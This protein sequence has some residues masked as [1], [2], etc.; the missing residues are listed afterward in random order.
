VRHST[1]DF[2]AGYRDG[3]ERLSA[4]IRSA[5]TGAADRTVPL[6]P[7]WRV[8]D[9]VA[10]VVGVCEDSVAADYPDFSDPKRQPDQA[11]AREAWTSAQVARRR[12][13]PMEEVIA[14]WDVLGPQLEA[15]LDT[16]TGADGRP[17]AR[18]L[19]APFDLG[20]HL[21][22]V[23]HA[24]AKPGDHDAP[25]TQIAFALAR[26]WLDVRIRTAGLPALRLQTTDRD[27]V[28][29]AGSAAV[30]VHGTRF[31]LF[32][33]ITGRRSLPQVL[34]MHWNGDPSALLDVLSPYP[35]PKFDVLE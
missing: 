23:R 25:T 17:S 28:L 4:L 6:T 20:C 19:G 1:V 13:M 9:V 16:D 11:R 29:G 34:A 8:R 3:R 32:R 10:H 27:W 33:T 14:Q 31:G 2:A 15:I 35:I 21:H 12:D 18:Q 5:G 24:L 22:D 26:G 7:A 30:R